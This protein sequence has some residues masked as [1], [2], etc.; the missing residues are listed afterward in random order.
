M[1]ALKTAL[2]GAAGKYVNLDLSGN[3]LISLGNNALQGCT[4]ITSVIFPT[5]LTTIGEQAFAGCTNLKSV[6]FKGGSVA[7]EDDS[8]PGG[9]SLKTA[10][11]TGSTG[12]YTTSDGGTTWTK[13]L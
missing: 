12:T 2:T 3:V 4:T 10:Y 13:S 9:T 6:E 5:G 11:T 7:I 8:F 1:T